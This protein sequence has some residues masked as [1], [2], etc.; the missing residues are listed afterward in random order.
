[1][2]MTESIPKI[3]TKSNG[4]EIG[5]VYKGEFILEGNVS[6]RIYVDTSKPPF[7]VFKTKDN[8]VYLN[9]ETPAATRALYGKLEVA[10]QP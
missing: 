8:V 2:N 1:L 7:I 9:L 4:L 6:A 10:R 5:S 3:V